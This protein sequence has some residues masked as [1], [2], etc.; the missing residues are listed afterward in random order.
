MFLVSSA[1]DIVLKVLV[2]VWREF[3]S[4]YRSWCDSGAAPSYQ[5]M[6]RVVFYL[7]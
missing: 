3:E 5:I 2:C 6:I 7:I 1:K 4:H